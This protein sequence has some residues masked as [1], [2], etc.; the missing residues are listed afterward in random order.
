[1][2][3]WGW[4]FG[5]DQVQ[6]PP[7]PPPPLATPPPA[8]PPTPPAP[9]PTNPPDAKAVAQTQDYFRTFP[10]LG[11]STIST[12]INNLYPDA[13]MN[14]AVG[15]E[16]NVV[17]NYATPPG[18]GG[19]GSATYS[20]TVTADE[21]GGNCLR[22]GL[23]LFA[24]QRSGFGI[25]FTTITQASR[26]AGGTCDGVWLNAWSPDSR[27]KSTPD[28]HGILHR[29]DSGFTRIGEVN[30]GNAWGDFGLME[31]RMGSRFVAGLEFFP[32]WLSGY[33]NDSNPVKYHASW[34]Q[35]IGAAG[36]SPGQPIPKNWIGQMICPDGIVGKKD[37]PNIIGPGTAG[38]T[39]GGGGYAYQINGSNDPT[40]PIGKGINFALAMDVA[41]DM[42]SAHFTDAAM[43]LADDQV[44]HLG[45]TWL[46]GHQ[47][48]LQASANGVT[49]KDI[50][51]P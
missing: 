1:M 13:L 41:I 26:L 16:V 33:T 3:M 37:H 22:N 40:N 18:G 51:T 7:A 25:G 30:Y 43:L 49:W 10:T 19:I 34:A 39:S 48:R 15:V 32:D 47:G 50:F 24:V 42:R 46:R 45:S 20:H 29:Y 28:N 23:N 27:Y 5:G 35:A 31:N 9:M 12:R 44:I 4:L 11:N 8:T 17:N 38:N 21:D 14:D 36:P 6:P 2:S